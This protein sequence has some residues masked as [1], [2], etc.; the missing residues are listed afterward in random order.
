MRLYRIPPGDFPDI[1]KMKIHLND[2]D[3]K[4]FPKL[5]LKLM[6]KLEQVSVLFLFLLFLF[7][8]QV[9]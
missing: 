8:F 4:N 7:S 2:Y 9:F 6:E 1:E 5:D 3:F